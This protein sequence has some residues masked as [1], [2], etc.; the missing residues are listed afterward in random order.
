MNNL[1]KLYKKELTNKLMK[2][3]SLLNVMQVPKVLKVTLNMG[4]GKTVFDKKHIIKAIEELSL[5]SSQKAIA[6][7]V[8]KSEA[9][10]KI[11]AGMNIGCKVTLRKTRMYDFLERL[12][13]VALPRIRDFR[14]LSVKS[15]DKQGN[16]NLG[17]KEQIIFPEIDYDKIDIIRGL[18]IS[19]STSADNTVQGFAL[20]KSLGFPFIEKEIKK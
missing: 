10:F 11:R 9:G 3:L 13:Y 2:E 19:I 14:G 15:F 17:I 12:I 8:K 18:D 6:T 1:Q 16:Y 20:L 5:I 7:K 4:V